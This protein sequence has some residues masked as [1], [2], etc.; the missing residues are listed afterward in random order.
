M[1]RNAVV[2]LTVTLLTATAFI[3]VGAQSLP[4][5]A[6]FVLSIVG[7]NDVHGFVFD[8]RGRGGVAVLG[9]YIKN[10]RAARAA[11]GGAVMVLDAGDTYQGGIESDMSEGALVI[12]AYNAIGYTAAAIGNHDFEFGDV[13]APGRFVNLTVDPRG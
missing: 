12:D 11:D 7:T 13:D 9:G 8:A 3:G 5:A 10:L 4:P 2:W 6:P 1:S